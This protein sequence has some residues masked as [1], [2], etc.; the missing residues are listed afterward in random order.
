MK[1]VPL[2]TI[3]VPPPVGPT[4]VLM[5]V[6]TGRSTNR[7]S[8]SSGGVSLP[9]LSIALTTILTT[10]ISSIGTGGRT[11]SMLQIFRG[12]SSPAHSLTLSGSVPGETTTRIDCTR[13]GPSS[14]ATWTVIVVNAP[15]I[16]PGSGYLIV[17]AGAARSGP[18]EVNA[19]DSF[20]FS[21]RGSVT[22]T[23]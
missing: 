8:N 19:W 4:I 3:S 14:A 11:P 16:P 15:T 5:D 23:S 21:P 6:T 13:P 20:A 7:Y 1:S 2:R 12:D 9:R 18:R 10:A 17:M 22:T